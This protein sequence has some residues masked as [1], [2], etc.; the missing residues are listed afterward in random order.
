MNNYDILGTVGEGAYGI[1]LKCR[2]K[3]TKEI[4][5][6]KKF[7]DKD[8]ENRGIKKVIVRELR[9]LRKL[10]HQNMVELKDVFKQN[11]RLY[12][13]FEFCQNSLLEILEKYDEM[14]ENLS[15]KFI[16]HVS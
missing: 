4:V 12:M 5:A 8:V 13:I 2:H 9:A 16:R 14:N 11:E 15:V 6:I 7:K 3:K 10:K 1:V